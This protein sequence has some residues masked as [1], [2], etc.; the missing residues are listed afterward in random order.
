M[1]YDS[2][3]RA[4]SVNG[5]GGR[6]YIYMHIRTRSLVIYIYTHTYA[7]RPPRSTAVVIHGGVGCNQQCS[8]LKF[9][10]HCNAQNLQDSGICGWAGVKRSNILGLEIFKVFEHYSVLRGA[11]HETL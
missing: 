2:L 10:K 3:E 8:D 11:G 5:G 1:P 7:R 6:P 4:W 9:T